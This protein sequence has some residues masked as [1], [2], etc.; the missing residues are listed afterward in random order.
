M[1]RSPDAAFEGERLSLAAVTYPLIPS[2]R[3]SSHHNKSG[4]PSSVKNS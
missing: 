2:K 1:M 3:E 4:S